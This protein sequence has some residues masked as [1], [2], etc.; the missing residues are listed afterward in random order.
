MTV[1]REG[2]FKNAL[3]VDVKIGLLLAKLHLINQNRRKPAG[4]RDETAKA[5]RGF[6][7]GPDPPES[8]G[9]GRRL[10]KL[11]PRGWK[12]LWYKVTC[13]RYRWDKEEPAIL[14][15]LPPDMTS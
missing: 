8:N 14:E 9:S 3:R 1:K 10:V 11:R 4:K 15:E 5:G 2:F 13:K 7:N 6:L 12:K